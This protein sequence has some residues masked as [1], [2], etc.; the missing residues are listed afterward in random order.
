[1]HFARVPGLDVAAL[2]REERCP[3]RMQSRKEIPCFRFSSGFPRL[4][5]G[6]FSQA[7]RQATPAAFQRV[8]IGRCSMESVVYLPLFAL[9]APS[10]LRANLLDANHEN[11][12]PSR[13]AV[14]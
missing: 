3:H 8:V 13:P 11:A 5:D 4:D 10:P 6:G 9:F 7:P 2:E 14:R 12:I 1:M